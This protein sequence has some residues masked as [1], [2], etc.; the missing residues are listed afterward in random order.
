L[1]YKL[2][3][4]RIEPPP[5]RPSPRGIIPQGKGASSPCFFFLLYELYKLDELRNPIP[6][7]PKGKEQEAPAFSSYFINFT[8]LT[9]LKN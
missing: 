7:F 5:S 1:L 6:A 2:D 8:N 9:N 4:L 3:E